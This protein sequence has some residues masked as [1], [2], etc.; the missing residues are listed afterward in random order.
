MSFF[1]LSIGIQQ[2][3]T[4]PNSSVSFSSGSRTRPT[5]RLDRLRRLVDDADIE[6]HV[7]DL[8]AACTMTR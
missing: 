6:L 5:C 7:V 8:S 2:T 1:D 4:K 3:Y